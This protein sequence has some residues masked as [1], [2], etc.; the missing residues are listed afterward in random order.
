MIRSTGF[1]SPTLPMVAVQDSVL[2]VRFKR[3]GTAVEDL[4]AMKRRRW[5][6]IREKHFAYP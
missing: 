3:G 5:G 4:H 6:S 1:V 2:R